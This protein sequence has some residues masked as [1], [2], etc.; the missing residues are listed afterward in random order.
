MLSGKP[1]NY[2]TYLKAIAA[3]ILLV[4]FHSCK[5][6]KEYPEGKP[7]VYKTNIKLT[8]NFSKEEKKN[9]VN[10]LEEQLD[11]SL[12]VRWLQK[13]VWQVLKKPPV[14]DS[15]NA[16]KSII[17]MRGLLKS[18]GYFS[19]SIYFTTKI[20]SSGKTQLRTTVDFY[21]RPGKL[22]HLDTVVYNFPQPVEFQKLADS[23]KGDAFVKKG[24]P[25]AKNII[26]A[27]LDRL[28]EIYRN[29]GYLRFNRDELIGLWDTLDVS[30]LQPTLDP[31]EQLEILQKLQ[32]R[33]NNPS[34]NLEIR[35]RNAD[36]S[37]LVK[38]YI[39]NTTIYPDYTADTIG[40]VPQIKVVEGITVIQHHNRFKP[41][42]FP[43]NIYLVHDSLYR[44]RRYLRTLAKF[45]SLSTWRLVN[46]T[47]LPRKNQD[48]VD[49]LIRLT[50][51]RKYSFSTNIEGSI[52]QSAIS[53]NLFGLGL[54]L[55]MVNRNYSKGANIQNMNLRYGIEFGN[56]GSSQFIQ[57]QQTSFTHSILFPRPI[58]PRLPNIFNIKLVPAD[59]RDN[60][61]SLFS[62]NAS[63]TERRLLYN[64]TT[65]SG[66]WGYELQRRNWL[67][68][69]KV[70]NIEYS[71]L[72][73]RDSL[74]KL[75][76]DNPSLKN[77]FTDGF[78]SSLIFNATKSWGRA[79]PTPTGR[80]TTT[81]NV[82]RGN[83]EYSPFIVGLFR[84]SFFDR[85]LYRF[86]KLDV[87]YARLIRY[88]KSSI[89]LRI[90]AGAGYELNSTRNEEKR[91]N[92]PFF[93]Q[94]FSGGPNSM[95]AWGLRRLGPGSSIKLYEDFPDRYGD[96]QLEANAEYRF[97][98]GRPFGVNLNGAVFTDIGNV[99][100]MKKAT[101]RPPEEVFKLSRLG[102]DIAVGAGAGLRVDLS[103]FVI[104]F[105]YSYKVK[106][107]SPDPSHAAIQ[108]KWFGY[109]FFDGDQ[110]QLGINYPFIF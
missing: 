31:F 53:G 37:R 80:K 9:L 43:P 58:I 5:V 84:N 66:A 87:E 13:L 94:Y 64:L 81:L 51:A 89:A 32:A 63:N 47:P 24:D 2:K 95:R 92:L 28:T 82:L 61:R 108:N 17:F 85:E 96:I 69:V 91:N 78:I 50:P 4:A 97:P 21:V 33:R 12:E 71:Y 68:T 88:V 54:N 109:S 52:N 73:K 16:D 105:D 70:P 72:F 7:F 104:R 55:G 36:S 41:K 62:F 74:N 76:V 60:I 29:N 93:K 103:F 46:I 67:L 79:A 90:F 86:V 59:M 1:L 38:Y 6:V 15:S 14:Y 102:K 56:S 19:D 40:L 99:W 77:I 11:D 27:E 98:I 3:G 65:I 75:I 100:F 110:F 35:L 18:L 8:G 57:S 39:G 48:T 34:A 107:P 42:I 83:L 49:F 26:S 20:D 25:F 101:D 44:Q 22:V 23:T 45:N 30:L 106:D 10:G